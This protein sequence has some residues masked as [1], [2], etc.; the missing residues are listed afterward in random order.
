MTFQSLCAFGASEVK[1]WYPSSLFILFHTPDSSSRVPGIAF[2]NLPQAQL[3]NPR[4]LCELDPFYLQSHLWTFCFPFA[5]TKT[6]LETKQNK[7]QIPNQT[8]K[9]HDSTMIIMH[10][11][12]LCKGW[13]LSFPSPSYYGAWNFQA[14]LSFSFTLPWLSFWCPIPYCK[15]SI[16]STVHV[17]VCRS[18]TLHLCG[19]VY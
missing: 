16:I 11:W 17:L 19:T 3:W 13:M 2:S 4:I 10:L 18:C 1:S 9:N 8:N 12:S 7:T 14:I 15:L 6:W 5:E